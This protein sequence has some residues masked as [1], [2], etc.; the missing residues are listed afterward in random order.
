VN[1]ATTVYEQFKKAIQNVD[2]E[3]ITLLKVVL[4]QLLLKQQQQQQ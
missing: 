4:S 1:K 3:R 2:P